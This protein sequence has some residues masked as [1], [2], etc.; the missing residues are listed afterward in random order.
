MSFFYMLGE[1]MKSGHVK[2]K[3][4]EN[5]FVFW[6]GSYLHLCYC[7]SENDVENYRG[8]EMHVLAI[9]ELTHFS[10]F[11]YRFLRGRVRL[12][13]LDIPDKYK[14][15]LPR[16]EAG[17]NPGSVGHA[18]VKRT[19][20]APKPE[21]EKWHTPPEEG[22]MLRQ[23]IPAKLADNSNLLRDDPKYADR[24]RGLGGDH[25]VR[26]MLDGDWNIVAGQAYEKLNVQT[27]GLEPFEIPKDWALFRSMDWGSSHPFSVGWWAVVSEDTYVHPEKGIVTGNVTGAKKLRRGA[28]VRYREWYGWNGQPDKGLRLE[29]AEVARGIV[30]RSE[31]E[32]YGYTVADSA[33]WTVDG[34]PSIAET[35]LNNGVVLRKAIKGPNSRHVGYAEVRSRIAGDEDGPMLYAF[36]T[37]HAGFWRTMPDLV[38]DDSKYGVNSESVETSQEDHVS[39]EVMYYC[40]SRPWIRSIEVAREKPDRWSRAFARDELAANDWKTI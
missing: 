34:A 7:D 19:F 9:D 28:I 20:V 15:K 3:S 27:H 21:F 10:E 1:L 22:G 29:A 40:T 31:G 32:K 2:Y 37:C 26:A 17:S 11:Q 13:G 25:L 14:Q 33:M 4:V 35:F 18:W 36:K 12:A 23:F 8:S 16:I 5:E 6:N 24:V 30:L 39:D 38:L